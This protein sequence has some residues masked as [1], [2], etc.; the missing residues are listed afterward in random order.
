MRNSQSN[1]Y[2]ALSLQPLARILCLSNA[3][4]VCL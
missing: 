2:K 1:A 4:W 3:H